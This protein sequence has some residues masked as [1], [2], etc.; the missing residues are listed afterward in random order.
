MGP[1]DPMILAKNCLFLTRPGISG[2]TAT[3]E[4]LDARAGDVFRWMAEGKLKLRIDREFP[5]ADAAEAHRTIE[6]RGTTGKLL[7]KI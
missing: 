4:E 1:V 6:G 5:L 3:R 2:Y 7:L